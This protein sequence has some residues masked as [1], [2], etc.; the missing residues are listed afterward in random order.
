MHGYRDIFLILLLLIVI[1]VLNWIGICT[2]EEKV[3]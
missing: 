1:L 3:S 2:P